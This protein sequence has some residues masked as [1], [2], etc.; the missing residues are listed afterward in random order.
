M[1]IDG[2]E[3]SS[4]GNARAHLACHTGLSLDTISQVHGALCLKSCPLIPD[5]TRSYISTQAQHHVTPWI[6]VGHFGPF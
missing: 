2:D 5:K 3:P 4:P 1:L 6:R